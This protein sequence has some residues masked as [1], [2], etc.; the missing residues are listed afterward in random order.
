MTKD[1][2]DPKQNPFIKIRSEDIPWPVDDGEALSVDVEKP[3]DLPD[4]NGKWPGEAGYGGEKKAAS[5]SSPAPDVD[6]SLENDFSFEEKVK[7]FMEKI[8]EVIIVRPVEGV[9]AFKIEKK[10]CGTLEV[11]DPD[12]SRR[13]LTALNPE[14]RKIVNYNLYVKCARGKDGECPCNQI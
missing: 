13:T 11:V 7:T 6:E 8:D 12:G 14:E 1:Y 3:I 10:Q 5:K 9:A 4:K 2:L